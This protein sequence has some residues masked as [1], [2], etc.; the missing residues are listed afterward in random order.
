MSV[1]RRPSPVTVPDGTPFTDMPGPPSGQPLSAVQ[2][3]VFTATTLGAVSGVARMP[4]LSHWF[5]PGV[6]PMR[7]Y[8]L[9]P[10]CQP[11][12]PQP[13]GKSWLRLKMPASRAASVEPLFSQASSTL[14]VPPKSQSPAQAYGTPEDDSPAWK[15]NLKLFGSLLSF[16]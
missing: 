15:L 12:T 11:Y 14:P 5:G 1:R 6:A 4:R 2:A 9:V 8:V 13:T 3:L 16:S 7:A 10:F